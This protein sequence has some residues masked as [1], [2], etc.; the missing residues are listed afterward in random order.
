[1]SIRFSFEFL[2]SLLLQQEI[3]SFYSEKKEDKEGN[4]MK[5]S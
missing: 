2:I 1:M 4:N 3:A 5:D